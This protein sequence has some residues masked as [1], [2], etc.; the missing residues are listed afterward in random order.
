MFYRKPEPVS[1]KRVLIQ[2]YISWILLDFD[3]ADGARQVFDLPKVKYCSR[4]L[5]AKPGSE[6]HGISDAWRQVKD[7]PRTGRRSLGQYV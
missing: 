2:F 7:L 1:S 3:F 4:S 6:T 5:T